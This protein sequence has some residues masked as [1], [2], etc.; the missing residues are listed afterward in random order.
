MAAT[1]E[2]VK[3]V[4]LVEKYKYG[5]VT[6]IEM[7]TA[8]KG[9]SAKTSCASS[10]PRRASRNGCSSGGSRPIATGCT[11]PE[12]DWAAVSFPPIDYQDSYYY[13]A[14]KSKTDG[15]KSLDEVDPE[16]LE[17]YK[18]LGIPL[19][20]QERLAGVAVDAVFD[21]VSVATTFKGKLEAM[22]V[23]FCSISEAVQKHPELV[24]KYLGSVVPYAD[25]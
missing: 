8:P 6:D 23:I 16:L 10:R 17:T 14:P 7:E 15:P 25:N 20:E 19:E 11:M 4:E 3:Q 24:K 22:G 13:A 2:T 5:F 1:V 18:K 9:L 12:P 21:S